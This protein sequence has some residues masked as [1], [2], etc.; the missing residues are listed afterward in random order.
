MELTK[1]ERMELADCTLA[2]NQIDLLPVFRS[3]GIASEV[4]NG[5]RAIS[6]AHTRA[7]ATL[8]NVSADLFL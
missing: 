3:K 4:I 8:F 1:S 6:K 5:K 7:L 2:V